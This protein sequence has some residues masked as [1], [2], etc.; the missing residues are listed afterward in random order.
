[1]EQFTKERVNEILESIRIE[2]DGI[3]VGLALEILQV[4]KNELLS[5][6]IKNDKSN[7]GE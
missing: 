7:Q 6:P 1:M 4:L 2:F 3:P 5:I